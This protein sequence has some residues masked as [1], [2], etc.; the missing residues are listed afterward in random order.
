MKII[1]VNC[2]VQIVSMMQEESISKKGEKKFG[3]DVRNQ[4]KYQVMITCDKT[5]DTLTACKWDIEIGVNYKLHSL[6]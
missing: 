3:P 1:N 4:P 5:T 2:K 6:L